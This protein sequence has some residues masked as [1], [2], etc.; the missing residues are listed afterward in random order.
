MRGAKVLIPNS[1]TE[2]ALAQISSFCRVEYRDEESSISKEDLYRGLADAEGLLCYSRIPISN[3]LL[4]AAPNL[5]Y[6]SNIAVGYD[7]F[8][9]EAMHSRGV[10]G[11][12]TPEVLNETTADLAFALLMAA[13][14]RVTEADAY[15]KGGCWKQWT[16]NLMVGKDIHG[17]TLGIVG[18]GR[19][20]QVVARRAFGFDMPV[21]Y[22]NRKR[23]EEAEAKTG[24]TYVES[25]Y[26]LLHQS[27]FVVLLTPLTASTRHLIGEQELASMKNDAILINV[28]RGSVVDESALIRA[29]QNHVIAGA[30]LDVYEQEPVAKDNPLLAMPNVVSLPHIGSAT[31]E[32]RE[33]M[34]LTAVKNLIEAMSGRRPPNLVNPEVWGRT[35]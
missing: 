34:A 26:E 24:A 8:D 19:I 3:E 10:M 16:S 18:M 5:R 31:R 2:K 30:A 29:L 35:S 7:N 15:V 28:A 23:N 1:I 9:L 13:A 20:G 33:K 32:T 12:N 14:R 21:L 4:A 27:D 22:Y 25:L 6:V 17:S 11:T